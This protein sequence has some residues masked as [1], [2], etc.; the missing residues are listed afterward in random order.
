MALGIAHITGMVLVIALILGIG[1]Y[2]GRKVTNASDFLTG[3]G[4]AGFLLVAGSIMGTLVSG[5]TTLGTA[6]LAFNYGISAWSY[7][8]GSGIGCLTL[9]LGYAVSLR[10]SHARTLVGIV[11]NEFGETCGNI[12]SILTSTGIVVSIIAQIVAVAALLTTILP[13]A[14]TPAIILSTLLM[15]A[16]VIW[17]GMMGVGMGGVVKLVLLYMTAIAGGIIVLMTAGGFTG[18]WSM[19]QDTLV[20]TPLGEVNNI[21]DLS[22]RY[23]SFTARGTTKDL[24]NILS[25]V[26]GILTTQSYASAIWSGKTDRA[27]KRGA[28]FSACM[29][30]PIGFL[31]MLIGTFMRG[32]CLTT[33]EIAALT[34]AGQSIP[35]GMFEIASTSQVFPMFIMRYL[36]AFP[37]GVVLG[38]L[39]V[40]IVG[41]GA[42]LALG[43][44][45]IVVNDILPHITTR[46]EDPTAQLLATRLAIAVT[47]AGGA[48]VSILVPSAIIND[49]GFLSMGL[50]AAVA[51]GPLCAAMFL[52]GRVPARAAIVAAIVGPVAVMVCKFVLPSTIDPLFPGVAVALL[53][54]A[55][56]MILTPRG[57]S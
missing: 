3:G 25:V 57:R 2:S 55:A 12:V 30:P 8:I 13:I 18:L 47:L 50:R 11:A 6:Q 9:V 4:N 46:T 36:P 28:L 51:L 33:A 43:V 23:L 39:F 34:A 31:C 22:A 7:T 1:I 35:D 21:T 38:T 5:Q 24:G 20:S 52:P 49:Y 48:V 42:G 44:A 56:G 54:L 16:Y 29:I 45:T 15:A 41:G 53:I 10:R 26:L 32:Q 14:T 40:T 17:G 37:A 27:A 19:L